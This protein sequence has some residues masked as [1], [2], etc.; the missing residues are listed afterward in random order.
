MHRRAE[1][2]GQVC[3]SVTEGG[4]EGAVQPQEDMEEDEVAVHLE[5]PELGLGIGE[6]EGPLEEARAAFQLGEE[7]VELEV[8]RVAGQADAAVWA[9]E[10]QTRLLATCCVG[11]ERGRAGQGNMVP[12]QV[13]YN[14][15]F[16]GAGRTPGGFVK[17]DGR[18]KEF[19]VL[20]ARLI[21]RSLRPGVRKGF[22]RD[23]QI[24][25]TVFSI[26]ESRPPDSLALLASSTA[27]SLSRVPTECGP[28]GGVR[29][30]LPDN[31]AEPLLN[32]RWEASEGEAPLV[33]AVVAGGQEGVVMVEGS[34]EFAPE[35]E[36]ER[37]I[38]EGRKAC[39]RVKGEIE[40][41]A[42]RVGRRKEV[43]AERDRERERA[44]EFVER[45]VG[46]SVRELAR[47]GGGRVPADKLRRSNARRRMEAHAV[48]QAQEEELDPGLAR[49]AVD[50]LYEREWRRALLEGLPRED[51]RRADEM[52][53]VRME[54]GRLLPSAHGSA[55]FTRGETQALVVTTLGGDKEKQMVDS[56]TR[57]GAKDFTLHYFFPPASVGEAG[58]ISGMPSR[59]EV[60]HGSLAEKALAPALP[61]MRSGSDPF[62]YS[63]RLES[64]VTESNGSSSMASVCGGTLS[65]LDAGVPLMR[66]VAGVA[67]GRVTS[68]LVPDSD[69]VLLSDILG[70]EDANGDMD[71]KVAGGTDGVTAVQLDVKKPEGLPRS[72]VAAAM[73]RARNH[74][75]DLLQAMEGECDPP[76]TE[77]LPDGVERISTFF[78]DPSEVGKVIGVSGAT[79]REITDRTGCT[80]I[81]LDNET[82][83]GK[84][85]GPDT[86]SVDRARQEALA[87]AGYLGEGDVFDTADVISVASYGVVLLLAPEVKCLVHVSSLP[88]GFLSSESAPQY[89][90][91]WR[92]R[93]V[94]VDDRGIKGQLVERMPRDEVEAVEP[95]SALP[96]SPSNAVNSA[97]NQS[98]SPSVHS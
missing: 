81:E 45:A 52:R 49:D 78:V 56:P 64:T 79:V 71:F 76:P 33:D 31:G 12:L 19:E 30:V 24:C 63:V 94:A 8:G 84:A 67:V 6:L 36:W 86:V 92:V 46:E 27:L 70:S 48:H 75:R 77:A 34:G 50:G 68:P 82:G 21:D 47:G 80:S 42:E 69:E 25:A 91:R 44:E 59:R 10:G 90:E 62:P 23:V 11:E 32:P 72:T 73:E 43:E 35:R 97:E 38:E 2:R 61:D 41:L 88:E 29:V 93:V 95:P 14:E 60:G 83:M 26:D 51:G 20:I 57:P 89:G 17:R 54:S 53:R 22:P 87:V 18:I 98:V 5:T 65:L 28:V 9:K 58:R 85:R 74:I 7:E 15:R 40:G 96:S 1:S 39:A 13:V 4:D 16:S 55:L 66:R 3:K 37:A